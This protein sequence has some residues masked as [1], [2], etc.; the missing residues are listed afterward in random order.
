MNIKASITIRLLILDDVEDWL[1]QC[2]IIDS[3]SGENDIYFGP[4][5]RYDPFPTEE[6]RERTIER[7]GKSKDLPNW[8]RAWGIF[9]EDKIVGN[10][11]ISAGEIST[12]LHRVDLGISILKQYRNIG[13]GKRLLNTVIQWCREEPSIHW[14]DL[15]V[16]FGNRDA[17]ILFEKVGFKIIGYKKDAW[18]I[19]EKSIS[20]TLM[21]LNVK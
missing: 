14:I 8:R 6:I 12:N 4:Y 11:Q 15:G 2:E 9:H 21:S 3:E 7:W 16:F 13:L 10:A 17:K 18:L 20:E 5:S 1:E 19:D